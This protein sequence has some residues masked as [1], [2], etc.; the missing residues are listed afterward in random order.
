M[1]VEAVVLTGGKSERMGVDKAELVVDG[2]PLALR[3]ARSLFEIGL[4]VT[5]LGR[6]KIDGFAFLPDAEEF[7]G[8]LVA[9]GGFRPSAEFVFVASCDMPRF[10]P[11]IAQLLEG[12]INKSE[13]GVPLIEEK[14]QPTCGIYRQE[15]WSKIPM[16][17]SKGKKS[18][19][20]WLDSLEIRAVS[21]GEIRIAGLD[22]GS[23]KGVNTPEGFRA[24]V[25]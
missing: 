15:A 20:A 4:P 16:V 19:M 3:I 11:R 7:E 17:L 8:P 6:K 24:M 18:L 21:E 9:L 2:E 5:V 12:L 23:F 1:A 10:D 25:D 13:A 14:L 22:P